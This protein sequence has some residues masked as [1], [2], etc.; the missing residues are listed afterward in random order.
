MSR[1][2]GALVLLLALGVPV[3]AADE[4]IVIRQFSLRSAW[5]DGAH[6]ELV[7][8]SAVEIT[9]VEA[10]VQAG[11][12]QAAVVRRPSFTPARE[13][14]LS[15]TVSPGYVPPFGEIAVQLSLE[16]AAGE[17]VRTAVQRLRYVDTRFSWEETTVGPLTVYWH[18]H[19]ANAAP[20]VLDAAHRTLERLQ[21]E[22][23]LVSTRP[24][25]IVVYNSKG[26]IDPALPFRSATTQRELV[27][28]GQAQAAY[29]LV[30]VLAGPD[31]A[32][33]TAHELTHLVVIEAAANPYLDLP[34]WLNEGLA[35]YFQGD[36]GR[37]YRALFERMKQENRLPSLRALTTVPGRPEE[38]LLL[39]GMGYAVVRYLIER[40]GPEKLAAYLSAY[41]DAHDH[42]E[43]LRQV[44]GFDRDG[45][46]REWRIATGAPLMPG[47]QEAPPSAARD[48]GR[49]RAA[50]ATLLPVLGGVLLIAVV[51]WGSWTCW[52]RR[53]QSL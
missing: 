43:P 8:T 1:L 38:N 51:G 31:V 30:L 52:R 50:A 49:L 36:E 6:V 46:E 37:E 18:A 27:T 40:Y 53:A 4:G 35:V 44:Y 23:G 34:A 48:F 9:A 47:R 5:P 39:Y 10:A 26:E 41:R 15:F 19:G 17:R 22:A 16:N 13:L 2:L 33:T 25:T 28:T 14:A 11:R 12:Q 24:I 3:A 45:L 42:D 7:A 20:V 21:R 29:S 32:V